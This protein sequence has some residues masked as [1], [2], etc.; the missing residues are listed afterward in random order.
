MS[1]WLQILLALVGGGAFVALGALGIKALRAAG[2]DAARADRA[3]AD[4]ATAK[5]QA[6]VMAQQRTIDDAADR[7]ARGDF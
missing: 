4:L 6:D 7:L 3:E 5:K 1:V 2:A